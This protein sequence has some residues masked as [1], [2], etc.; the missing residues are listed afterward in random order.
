M[1]PVAPCSP[2]TG[3]VALVVR[4]GY[5]MT[6]LSRLSGRPHLVQ[7]AAPSSTLPPHDVQNIMRHPFRSEGNKRPS[8]LGFGR[9]LCDI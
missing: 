8:A 3:P 2:W 9:S 7:K 4:L 6:E 5:P 1:A